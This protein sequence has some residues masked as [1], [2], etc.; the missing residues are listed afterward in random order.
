[1]PPRHPK[2]ATIEQSR[3]APPAS[4]SAGSYLLTMRLYERLFGPVSGNIGELPPLELPPPALGY[5]G[6]KNEEVA[7]V[8]GVRGF[9]CLDILT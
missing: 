3:A 5:L 7:D 6:Q 8:G 2:R 1:M 9:S 4:R